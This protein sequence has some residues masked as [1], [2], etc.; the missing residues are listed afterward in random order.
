LEEEASCG[1]EASVGD[2]EDL[3]A[4]AGSQVTAARPV[5]NVSCKRKNP[6]VSDED[7]SQS[8]RTVLGP[9]P[10]MGH[11]RVSLLLRNS[12]LLLLFKCIKFRFS[13]TCLARSFWMFCDGNTLLLAI[14]E[15]RICTAVMLMLINLL[16]YLFIY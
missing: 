13:Y 5:V 9:P 14:H 16:I 7:L 11:S 12:L 10:P 8:W 2:I 4:A 15:S 1:A 6:A 3:S